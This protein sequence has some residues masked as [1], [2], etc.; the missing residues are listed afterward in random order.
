MG[1]IEKGARVLEDVLAIETLKSQL[2]SVKEDELKKRIMLRLNL[3]YKRLYGEDAAQRIRWL[4]ETIRTLAW[5]W[6]QTLPYVSF[7]LFWLLRPTEHDAVI[8]AEQ[9]DLW[10]HAFPLLGEKH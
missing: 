6:G 8:E 1:D 4:E 10:R 9:R 2:S 5:E 7:D 3:Y